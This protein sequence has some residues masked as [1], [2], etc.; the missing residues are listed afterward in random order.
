MKILRLMQNYYP[1]LG[2]V[3]IATRQISQRLVRD[4]FDVE[5][6]CERV[7]GTAEHETVDGVEIHRVFGFNLPKIRY[8]NESILPKMMLSAISNDADIIHVHATTRFISWLTLFSSKPTV[9]T[10]HADPSSTFYL[11]K[12]SFSA[13][14]L[15][16]CNRVV[17][18][19]ET[20]KQYLVNVGVKAEKIDVI[21]NGVTLPPMHAPSEDLSKIIV[22]IARLDSTHK[23]QDTLIKAMPKV[24][25]VIPDIKLWICGTGNDFKKLQEMTKTLNVD[26]SV[27]LKGPIDD[28]TKA[29]YMKNCGLF[30]LPSKYEAF[31][32]V[33]TEAMAYGR[34]IVTTR[35]GGI[36]SVVKDAA[37]LVP[38]DDPQALADALIKVLSNKGLADE[39]GRR[40]LERVKQ[41]DW[42]ITVKKYEKLYESLVQ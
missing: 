36:P 16:L 10:T 25:S 27:E 24:L 8:H 5:V 3:E 7:E 20:E 37:L 1:L 11:F 35:I 15:K 22:C 34:P 21:P 39:L 32:N 14:P 19:T 41:F 6:V 9:L 33:F 29:L 38:P 18:L 23:G 4:G 28:S 42:E 40:G 2:G 13:S 17:A 30:C 31:G 26:R 12:G